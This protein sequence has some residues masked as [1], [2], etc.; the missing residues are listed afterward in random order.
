VSRICDV[1]GRRASFGNNVSHANN[2][3]RRLWEPNLQRVRVVV[4]GTPKKLRVCSRCLKAERVQ[5]RVRTA[6]PAAGA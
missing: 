3:T 1:C 6:R 4:D 2:K 5:K